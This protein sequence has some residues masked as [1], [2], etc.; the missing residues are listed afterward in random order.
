MFTMYRVDRLG[1]QHGSGRRAPCWIRATLTVATAG[2]AALAGA[3]GCSGGPASGVTVAAVGFGTVAQVVQAPANVVPKDQVTLSAAADGTVAALDVQDGQQVTA[4][5]VLGS[6]SSPTAQQQLASAQEA[7]AQVSSGDSGI[8]ATATGFTAAASTDESSAN[9]AF[10]QAKT[11]AQQITDPTLQKTLL[12]EID[13][14]QSSYDSAISTVEGV[15]GQFEQGLASAGQVL[16]ALDEAQRTQA[17]AAVDAAQSTISALTVTAPISGTVTLDSGQGGSGSSGLGSLNQIISQAE[18]GAGAAGSGSGSG[19]SGS[20]GSS[21]GG[22]GAS[23]GSTMISVGTPVSAGNALYTITDSSALTIA[24]QVD[25]TDVLTVHPGV[26]AD[27]QL[28]AV[29]G[30]TYPGTVTA[31]DPTAVTSS[32]GNV[33]YTVR[34]S[35]GAGKLQGG[36]AAPTPLPGMSAIANLNVLTAHHTLSVPSSALIINGQTTSVWVVSGGTAQ[37][38]PI[39][40]GAQGQTAVQVLSGLKA[41]QQIVVNG[42]DKVTAGEQVG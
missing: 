40:L 21:A 6:I 35:L 26:T 28:N 25:E 2:A 37:L 31:V 3:A 1:N 9:T 24:A 36:G 8:P 41:G 42:A 30:A 16:D 14:A 12:D 11:A 38:H 10:T 17:Q 33:T 5:E 39:T 15:V 4:G 20:T 13:A 19:S 32:Q 34:L 27:I 29:P 18:S 22:S 7:L 23:G